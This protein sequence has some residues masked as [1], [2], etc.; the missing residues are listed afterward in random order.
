M[1]EGKKDGKTLAP[2]LVLKKLLA[3]KEETFESLVKGIKVNKDETT[4]VLTVET[5]TG[6]VEACITL[7]GR[8]F[9][10]TVKENRRSKCFIRRYVLIIE[11]VES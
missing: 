9:S 1:E 8:K 11:R 2:Y 6:I 7:A 10:E 3:E 4:G 5:I